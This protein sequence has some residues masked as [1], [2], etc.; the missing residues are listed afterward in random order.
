M[1]RVDDAAV[2]RDEAAQHRRIRV[3]DLM[4]AFRRAGTHHLVAGD[5][6][7]HARL[8]DDR[9][10]RDAER[11]EQ[12]RDPAAASDR[13]GSQHGGARPD[14]LAAAADVL[15]GGNR[16]RDLDLPAASRAYSAGTTASAPA[17]NGAPVM[18]R[19]A[20][21]GGTAPSNGRPGNAWPTTAKAS[22]L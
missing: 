18:M 16:E 2:A 17:G 3:V 12:A 11:G 10:L 5:D 20:L 19:T 7:A 21:A 15:A 9:D 6:D 13:P 22:G 1:V 14:V 4:R 8:G